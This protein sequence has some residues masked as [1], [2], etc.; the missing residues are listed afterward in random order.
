MI[1]RAVIAA[2]VLSC[3]LHQV[4][5]PTLAGFL[6]LIFMYLLYV[7]WVFKKWNKDFAGHRTTRRNKYSPSNRSMPPVKTLEENKELILNNSKNHAEFDA[8]ELLNDVKDM[9]VTRK[10]NEVIRERAKRTT[11]L[12]TGEF[13]S[14]HGSLNMDEA[15]DEL[16]MDHM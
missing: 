8:W 11:S 13:G 12:S 15:A 4:P 14:L 3:G 6:A 16:D 2:L 10:K 5:I 9:A 1:G 7:H